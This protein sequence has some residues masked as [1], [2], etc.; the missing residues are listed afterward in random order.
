MDQVVLEPI[1]TDVGVGSRWMVVI[2]NN[3]TNS[4]DEV[5]DVLIRATGCSI[6]E[7]AIETWEAHTYG[8][9]SVHFASKEDCN[10]A[11]SI[12]REIGVAT[13]V[14]PEWD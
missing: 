12:I 4:A 8:K 9:A 11:A 6:E 2:S 3:D 1:N 7:A 14:L 5:I 13:D 10:V